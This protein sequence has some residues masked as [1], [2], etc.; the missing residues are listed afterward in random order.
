MFPIRRL[1]HVTHFIVHIKT[2]LN[3]TG[4]RTK[5]F[6]ANVALK[7]II[8]MVWINDTS[9]P[10]GAIPTGGEI[11]MIDHRVTAIGGISMCSKVNDIVDCLTVHRANPKPS[12]NDAYRDGHI[13][14][15]LPDKMKAPMKMTR[16]SMITFPVI[17][18]LYKEGWDCKLAGIYP[19]G[20]FSSLVTW[21]GSFYH[22]PTGLP[23][24]DRSLT[25]RPNNYAT[26]RIF[27]AGVLTSHSE[28][29]CQ[30]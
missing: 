7:C 25:F 14:T 21:P 23:F 6:K 12:G 4:R 27:R 26:N 3:R 28:Q 20:L 29:A 30:A 13:V 11:H 19:A 15:Y 10:P 24:A 18:L 5:L 8:D 9:D 16:P 17:W 2:H 1:V 22:V